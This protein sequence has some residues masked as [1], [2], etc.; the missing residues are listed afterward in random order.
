MPGYQIE[1]ANGTPAQTADCHYRQ[2]EGQTEFFRVVPE[3]LEDHD[4]VLSKT[5]IPQSLTNASELRIASRASSALN[6]PFREGLVNRIN[7]WE[8]PKYRTIP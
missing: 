5:N 8:G 6:K 7:T 2:H 3:F 4:G 1:D